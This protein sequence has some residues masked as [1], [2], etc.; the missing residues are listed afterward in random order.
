MGGCAAISATQD[1]MPRNS[2]DVRFGSKADIEERTSD[3]RYSPE[4]GHCRSTVGCPLSAKSGC[5][6][7][8]QDALTELLFNYSSTRA[9]TR[10]CRDRDVGV[11]CNLQVLALSTEY[12]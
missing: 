12:S 1:V 9:A 10:V 11:W 5:E 2:G 3:V 4:S 8:Q 6:Q 7:L